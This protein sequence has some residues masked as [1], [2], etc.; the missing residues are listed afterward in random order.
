VR[1]LLIGLPFGFHSPD[2]RE[3]TLAE[4][5]EMLAA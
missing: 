2:H 1:V 4:W 5:R 3:K